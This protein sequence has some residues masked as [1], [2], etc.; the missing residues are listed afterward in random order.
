MSGCSLHCGTSKVLDTTPANLLARDLRATPRHV[1]ARFNTAHVPALA[2]SRGGQWQQQQ[3]NGLPAS[4]ANL[5][6]LE[7]SS[8]S[9]AMPHNNQQA[10]PGYAALPSGAFDCA[11]LEARAIADCSCPMPQAM[12][13]PGGGGGGRSRLMSA[14]VCATLAAAAAA[15]AIGVDPA[16]ALLGLG[17]GAL[18]GM[19]GR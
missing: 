19:G 4:L 15:T 17:G 6:L 10:L 8:E 3:S 7:A 14:C 13:Q 16:A 9:G 11:S 5:S 1:V 18:P 12:P 2:T